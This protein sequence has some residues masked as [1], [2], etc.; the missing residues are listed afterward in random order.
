MGVFAEVNRW[1]VLAPILTAFVSSLANLIFV[2]PAT[3][4]ILLDRQQQGTFSSST[5]FQVDANQDI[6]EEGWKE[7]H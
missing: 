3:T 5:T 2:G 6:R 4:K 1:T 7:M